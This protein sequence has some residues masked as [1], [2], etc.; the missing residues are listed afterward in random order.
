MKRIYY[1]QARL[2]LA[3]IPYDSSGLGELIT[4][5]DVRP[6][7]L[8]VVSTPI[9]SA[10]KF[11][12]KIPEELFPTDPTLFRAVAVA[13][14]MGNTKGLDDALVADDDT[15]MIL[16]HADSVEK[17]F[18]DA[19]SF[20]SFKGRDY[21][22]LLLDEKWQGRRVERGR[23]LSEIVR[24]VLDSI[25]AAKPLS[26]KLES[27]GFDP[28]VEVVGKGRRG[29]YYRGSTNTSVFECLLELALTVGASVTV[30]ADAV[31][32][33]R[34]RTFDENQDAVPFLVTAENLTKLSVQRRFGVSDLPNI[35]VT[36]YDPITNTTVVGQYPP[37][38]REMRR[39]TRARSTTTKS[40]QTTIQSYAIRLANPTKAKLDAVARR[41]F[42]ARAQQQVRVSFA[43]R[44]LTVR[45][46]RV[47]TG[48]RDDGVEVPVTN[49]RN[50]T[51]VRFLISSETR[52]VLRAAITEDERRRQL[53]RLAFHERVAAVLARG[54]RDIDKTFFVE[55]AT[56]RFSADGGYTL[57]GEASA[58]L[59]VDVEGDQ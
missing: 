45:E 54:W 35:R 32:I 15:L 26:V 20:V 53:V 9:K 8:E 19:G 13:G 48:R 10:D 1:P 39:A 6:I 43:T 42:D 57:T 56:H 44:D 3:L 14:Y 25:P 27:D 23:K 18:D 21:K 52:D 4:L 58:Y 51:P 59:T 11:S 40:K 49:I 34:P 30:R 17:N 12:I 24:D 33:G 36:A 28:E 55:T 47:Q 50:G 38:L 22:G 41:L 7:D 37:T 16:G 31:I 46:H 29:R 5:P 2:T